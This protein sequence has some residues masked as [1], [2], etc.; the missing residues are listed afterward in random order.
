MLSTPLSRGIAAILAVKLLA[1]YAIWLAF[2]SSPSPHGAGDV[3]RAL[4][5]QPRAP[6]AQESDR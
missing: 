4:L 5:T 6:A 2:F 1:L 3:A